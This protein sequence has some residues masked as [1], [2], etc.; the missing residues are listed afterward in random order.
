MF[1]TFNWITKLSCAGKRVEKHGEMYTIL[2][3]LDGLTVK[4]EGTPEELENLPLHRKVYLAIKT[5]DVAPAPAYVITDPV[6]FLDDD[7]SDEQSNE[8]K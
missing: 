5:T 7:T 6:T 1:D 8:E 3:Q 2:H 4:N